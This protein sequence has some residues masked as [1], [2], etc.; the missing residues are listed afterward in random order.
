[1][2]AD[3]NTNVYVSGMFLYIAIRF[4]EVVIIVE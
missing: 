3:K 4:C 1:M 2:E